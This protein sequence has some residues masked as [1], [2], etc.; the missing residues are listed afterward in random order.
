[1]SSPAVRAGRRGPGQRGVSRTFV[2]ALALAVVAGLG[3]CSAGSSTSTP[4]RSA[5]GPRGAQ[6]T[7]LLVIVMENHSS[8]GAAAGM[9]RLAAA[10][11]R[12]GLATRSFGV[13]H[14]SL[15]NYLAIAAGSTFSVHDDKPPSAHRL[16]GR[17]VFGQ[18]LASGKV[19]KTYAEGMTAPCQTTP[20]RR[21]AVKHNPWT[22][23]RSERAACLRDD[24][25]A[26]TP[27]RGALQHDIAAAA[28]PTF[29]LL[30]PDL[31]NDAHDCSLATADRWL[32]LWLAPLT[33]GPDFRAGRL[34]VVVTFDEDDNHSHNQILTAVLHESLHGSTVRTRLDHLALSRAASG[35]VGRGGLRGARTAPDLLT[36][37]GLAPAS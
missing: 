2:A 8:S 3:G 23:F 34:A 21:Y 17:S 4:A 24:V 15:P 11:H 14:P 12:Y 36:S 5:A 31:C 18:V 22:Y 6:P 30:I 1:M 9:P 20:S 19:A 10:A 32:G 7:K 26:G 25:P 29:A 13:T 33:A 37:F 35:L 16:P 28:M 27:S